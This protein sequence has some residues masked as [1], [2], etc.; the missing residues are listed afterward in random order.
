MSLL[1]PSPSVISHFV[2]FINI[3]AQVS[4]PCE[5]EMR[6]SMCQ[7]RIWLPDS[8]SLSEPNQSEISQVCKDSLDTVAEKRR[9][10]W[11]S[12]MR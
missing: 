5:V 11:K 12:T 9:A 8:P 4:A 10:L 1:L 7:V 6:E 2:A 3:L